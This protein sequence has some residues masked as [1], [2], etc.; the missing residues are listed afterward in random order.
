MGVPSDKLQDACKLA[1]AA[2]KVLP[3]V[4]RS[5][6]LIVSVS[7]GGS[8][9]KGI[10]AIRQRLDALNITLV[11]VVI[12]P[13]KTEAMANALK[14]ASSDLILM[15]TSYATSDLNETT[16]KAVRASGSNIERFGIPVDPGNLLFLGAFT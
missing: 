2:T 16:P 6:S 7:K 1:Q 15:L 8:G 10:G 13:H 9:G 3:P 11:E 12:T 4:M 14:N 5:V